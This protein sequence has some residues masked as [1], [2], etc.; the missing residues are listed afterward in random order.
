MT[1]MPKHW[2][3]LHNRKKE[4]SKSCPLSSCKTKILER[5]RKCEKLM[6]DWVSKHGEWCCFY[7]TLKYTRILK[8]KFQPLKVVQSNYVHGKISSYLHL[9]IKHEHIKI[10]NYK[11]MVK[12]CLGQLRLHFLVYWTSS[13]KSLQPY[14]LWIKVLM[15]KVWV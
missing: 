1:S 7:T 10:K 3:V 9:F 5:E 6:L 4:I 13:S 12:S 8:V 14:F 11:M 15:F 2:C